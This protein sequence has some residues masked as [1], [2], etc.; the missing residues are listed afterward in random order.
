MTT[1]CLLNACNFSCYTSLFTPSGLLVL[2]FLD[3]CSGSV[4]ENVVFRHQTWTLTRLICDLL[5]LV[6]LQFRWCLYV[7]AFL[8]R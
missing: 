8:C 4:G 7:V 3:K 5:T 6:A 2:L 1:P